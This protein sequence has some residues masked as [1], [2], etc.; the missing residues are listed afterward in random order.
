MMFGHLSSSKKC[1]RLY[2]A[3]GE[4]S[5]FALASLKTPFPFLALSESDFP[6]RT[7]KKQFFVLFLA[8][9]LVLALCVL[10]GG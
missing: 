4:N 2:I 8:L 10:R 5:L 7:K 6:I 1:V 9:G 3:W